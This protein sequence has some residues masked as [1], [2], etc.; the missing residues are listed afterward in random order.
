MAHCNIKDPETGLWNCWSTCVDDYLFDEWVPEDQYKAELLLSGIIDNMVKEDADY[1]PDNN[2]PFNLATYS[3]NGDECTITVKQLHKVDLRESSW[4]TKQ[5]CDAQ[6]AFLDKCKK[7]TRNNC[8]ACDYGDMF[9]PEDDEQ[10][11]NQ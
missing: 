7:C 1:D 10:C 3:I 5:G 8:S 2:Y 11:Q 4:H 9:E 6:K